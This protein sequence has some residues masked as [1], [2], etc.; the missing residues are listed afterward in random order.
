M[1]IQVSHLDIFS[2]L[3][4]IAIFFLVV[5]PGICLDNLKARKITNDVELVAAAKVQVMM[6]TDLIPHATSA[7]WVEDRQDDPDW[8]VIYA[9][10]RSEDGKEYQDG[11]YVRDVHFL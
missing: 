1:S 2:Q 6:E 11:F 3:N 5:C 10:K 9:A 8:L 4:Y 7:K